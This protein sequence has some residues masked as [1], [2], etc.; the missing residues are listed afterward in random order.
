MEIQTLF[1]N[2]AETEALP[3][4][5]G[6]C[7][8][9]YPRQVRNR[10]NNAGRQSSH[11][12]SG[13][14]IRFKTTA[15]QARVTLTTQVGDEGEAIFYKGAYEYTRYKLPQGVTTTIAL[16][17]VADIFN[18]Q[19]GKLLHSGGFSTDVW[20]LCLHRCA[21]RFHDIETFGHPLLP[22]LRRDTPRLRWLAYGSS[23]THAWLD[24]YIF[25]AAK[26]LAVDVANKGLGGGCQAEPAAAEFLASQDWDFITVE[27]GINMFR[28]YPPKAFK[29]QV[30]CF[31]HILRE[32]RPRKPIVII[33]PYR[34]GLETSTEP[35][36]K[37]GGDTLRSYRTILADLHAAAKDPLL[38]L[39]DG[40]EI[41]DRVDF[42]R[43]DLVHPSTHGHALMGMNLAR[44]LQPLVDRLKTTATP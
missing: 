20:R 31:L 22:L 36:A 5:P 30:K 35:E 23:I 33:T 25:M 24:G 18:G 6:F 2:V 42:L 29:D 16:P 26:L 9:R 19:S 34:N 32:A 41:L 13:I 12:G 4:L 21:V 15:P 28:D 8:Q 17:Y 44:L 27:L 3:G 10:L 40:N 1:H 7:L 37:E 43:F 39:L 14:E 11:D 38:T